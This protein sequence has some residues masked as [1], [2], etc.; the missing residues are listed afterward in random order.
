M[1]ARIIPFAATAEQ[2]WDAY[3]ALN[4]EALA[5]HHLMFDPDH[6]QRRA[7]AHE[8]FAR[9]FRRDCERDADV[10]ARRA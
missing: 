2:A 6:A 8:L 4:D 7:D 10:K 5:D 3:Q 1:T 9:L